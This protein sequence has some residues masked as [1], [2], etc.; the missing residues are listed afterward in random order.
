ML[1]HLQPWCKPKV[2]TLVGYHVVVGV[3]GVKGFAGLPDLQDMNKLIKM[4]D[5]LSITS[6]VIW[7]GL[8]QLPIRIALNHI[9]LSL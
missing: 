5:A 3:S 2:T 1:F 8:C 4:I 9:W 7:E 6:L